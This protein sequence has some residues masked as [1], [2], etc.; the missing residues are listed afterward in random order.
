MRTDG[1][2]G[3]YVTPAIRRHLHTPAPSLQGLAPAT[4][5]LHA[6]EARPRSGSARGEARLLEADD[7]VVALTG[8]SHARAV[9]IFTAD[10]ERFDRLAARLDVPA[11]LWNLPTTRAGELMP[12]FPILPWAPGGPYH[13]RDIL[14]P[15]GETKGTPKPEI[16]WPA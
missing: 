8:R 14:K 12:R 10:R 6:L 3:Y 13:R 2:L 11:V 1:R 16:P 5:R 4:L 9:S 15:G 7:A